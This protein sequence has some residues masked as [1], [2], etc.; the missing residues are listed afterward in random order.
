MKND[1][2][3]QIKRLSF[4]LYVMKHITERAL[5]GGGSF[6]VKWVVMGSALFNV[7]NNIQVKLFTVSKTIRKHLLNCRGKTQLKQFHSIYI[8]IMSTGRAAT[9]SATSDRSQLIQAAW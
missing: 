9:Y 3:A 6:W 8:L 2:N 5:A 7:R 1:L 4:F